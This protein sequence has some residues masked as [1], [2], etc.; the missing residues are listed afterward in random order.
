MG[1]LIGAMTILAALRTG[2]VDFKTIESDLLQ[3]SYFA[4]SSA[5]SS[6]HSVTGIG[7]SY[8]VF[9]SGTNATYSLHFTTKTFSSG[10]SPLISS[11]VYHTALAGIPVNGEFRAEAINP[12][13]IVHDMATSATVY[14]YIEYG[15]RK[16][17]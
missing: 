7:T 17:R 14:I 15:S 1:L 5:A 13:I 8:V 2:A 9:S 10:I 11:S 3:E 6:T 4:K 12:K 16:I